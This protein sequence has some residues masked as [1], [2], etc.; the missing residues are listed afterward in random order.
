MSKLLPAR[1]HRARLLSYQTEDLFTLTPPPLSYLAEGVIVSDALNLLA[2]R[3]KVGKSMLSLG[4]A[5]AI[6]KGER[7]Y[8]GL[9]VQPGRVVYIDAENGIG[10]TPRR[11]RRL[12]EMPV[13]ADNFRYLALGDQ[14]FRLDDADALDVLDEVVAAYEPDLIVLD[15]FR[16]LWTGDENNPREVA[17]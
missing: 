12:S 9:R 1:D 15:S 11:I 13:P 4:L 16:S 6:A 2:A 14:P 10:E 8:A 17:R 7:S 3:E 5:L